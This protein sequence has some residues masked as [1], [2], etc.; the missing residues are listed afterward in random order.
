MPDDAPYSLWI[1][2]TRR[3]AVVR[4]KTVCPV[5]GYVFRNGDGAWAI[6]HKGRI[7]KTVYRSASEAALAVLALE[8]IK[9]R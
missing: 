7:L 5:L 4:G 3:F 6:E 9:D 2:G 8:P 1:A